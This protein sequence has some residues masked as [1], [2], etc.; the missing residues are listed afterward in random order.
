MNHRSALSALFCVAAKDA[1]SPPPPGCR[2]SVVATAKIKLPRALSPSLAANRKHV[3]EASAGRSTARKGQRNS[4]T[5]VWN[6]VR[7]PTEIA[8]RAPLVETRTTV[9]SFTSASLSRILGVT[10]SEVRGRPSKCGYQPFHV[11]LP[12]V[13]SG[14]RRDLRPAVVALGMLGGVSGPLLS[15][16]GLCEGSAASDQNRTRHH[17]RSR[18]RV[19]QPAVRFKRCSTRAA[20]LDGST[21]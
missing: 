12:V 13:N 16:P 19:H 18:A 2:C 11:A 1:G 10:I 6:S 20:Q 21:I 5:V 15:H 8:K 17:S 3:S 9:Q 7:T 14:T 4:L